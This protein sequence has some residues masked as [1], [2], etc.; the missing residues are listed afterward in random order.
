MLIHAMFRAQ[1]LRTPDV[2]AIIGR[3]TAYTYAE[4]DRLTDAIAY[5]LQLGGVHPETVVGCWAHDSL[6]TVVQL[7]SVLKAG[8]AYLL[9]DP[10]LPVERVRYMIDDSD[11]MCI[12]SDIPLP[13]SL[14]GE[15]TTVLMSDLTQGLSRATIP[16]PAAGVAPDNLAYVAYTS[17]STGRPKGVLI[18][19]SAVSNHAT[20]MR[21]HLELRPGD[22]LPMMAPAAFDM[23]TEEILPPLVSGCTLVDAPHRSPSMRE[24]TEDIL[25]DGYTVLNISAPLWHRWTTYLQQT[26]IAVPHTLRLVIVGS[27]KI[28]TAKF[29]E[30]MSLPGAENVWWV[31]AYGVTEATVTSLLYLTAARDDLRDEALMPIGTP[32]DNVT[33]YVVGDDGEL[34]A[35]GEVGELFIG[36]AGLARGYCNLAGKTAERFGHNPFDPIPG[37]RYYRT[38]DLVRRRIDGTFV[39][40]GRYDSQI[41]INGLRIEPVEIEATIHD[42][43]AV[44]EA[45]VVYKPPTVAGGQGSLV[46]FVEA[47]S[48]NGI[49]IDELRAYLTTRLHPPMRPDEIIVLDRIPLSMNGKVD[50]AALRLFQQVS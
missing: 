50:R 16:V 12:L 3:Q 32:L 1:T 20:S 39:W 49:D 47:K 21:K 2:I 6:T 41:E 9:L 38:G 11:P 48:D 36:G 40:L 10:Q 24:F 27:D 13:S 31:A 43:P 4:L 26:G 30:W 18:T 33:A 15:R 8:G 28:Y 25:D 44:E 7:L 22:R 17:G 35:P 19:H 23:A 42:H 37:S 34:V 46:A 29:E 45:V 5:R 14:T